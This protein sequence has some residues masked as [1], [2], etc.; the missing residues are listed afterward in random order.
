MR[1]EGPIYRP[2]SEANSLL[3]QATA[4]CPHNRCTFC[5]IYKN[6]PRFKIRKNKDIKEDISEAREIY[7]EY[8]RTLFFPAG[9]TIA[10]KTDDLCEICSFARKTF[11]HLER[12]TVYGSSQFIHKKGLEDL[13]RL[14]EAGLSRIHVGLE[15]GDDVILKRIRKGTHSLQQTEA[16]K[17]IME[18]GMELSMYVILGIGGKD[19]TEPHAIETAKVLN[20]VEPDFIRLRTLV[21]KIN[22]P[23]LEEIEKGEFQPLGPHEVLKETGLLIENLEAR[24]YLASDHYTNYINLEGRL[25]REKT[26]FLEQINMSLKRDESSFRPFFIGTT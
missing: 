21:P 14:A 12:I 6:G 23:L 10:M 4:G 24:S 19:R 22:T 25:P 17:W 18:A 11:P 15:S 13:K 26:K 3:I 1:Y 16:G 7:G 2:P 9:N 8:V 20:N 5:M